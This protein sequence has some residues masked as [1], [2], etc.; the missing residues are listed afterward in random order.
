MLIREGTLGNLFFHIA[1]APEGD[2]AGG[3]AAAPVD[4]KAAPATPAAPASDA[5]AVPAA[6]PATPAADVPAAPA[7]PVDGKPAGEPAP[8]TPVTPAEPAA[9]VDWVKEREARI[10]ALPE[11]VR[12]NARKVLSKYA[13]RDAADLALAAAASKIT[14]L[15]EKAKGLVKVPGKDA[16]AEEVSAFDRAWGVPETAD[17]FEFKRAEGFEP[18]ELDKV[19]DGKA[20]DVLKSKHFNQEQVD[21]VVELD[22]MRQQ[23]VHDEMLKRVEQSATKAADTLRVAWGVNEYQPQVAAIQR[24]VTDVVMPMMS[25]KE[26]SFLDRRFADGT[27]L[28]EDPDFLKFMAQQVVNPWLDDNGMP[29]GEIGGGNASDDTKRKSEI[30]GL[31]S[32]NPK[33]YGTDAIQSELD[34]II[35]REQVRGKQK[36]A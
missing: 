28:G 14:E 10:N 7:V 13:S 17:K 31:M 11:D 9:A 23:M 12:E 19:F 2:G 33:L 3:G 29:R 20:K 25:N 21:A 8:A 24:Y 4:D 16:K 15:G 35:K 32:S 30:M 1:R 18:T 36:A 26:T 5:P 22:N 6:A 27:C 34:G